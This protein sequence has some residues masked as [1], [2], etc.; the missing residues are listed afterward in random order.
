[1]LR[2]DGKWFL[3]VTV[4]VPEGTQTPTT[5]FIGVDLGVVNIAVD[6]DGE[7]HS[8]EPIEKVRR[9]YAARRK[10]LDKA[11]AA[12]KRTGRRPQNIRR[13]KMR[14][15]QKESRFRRDV[16]H[17]DQQRTRRQG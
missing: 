7:R 10:T 17:R 14:Q 13:A 12:R 11:A 2:K 16:N 9:K 5:D 3:L 6:E 15:E 1:M 4:D 8:G